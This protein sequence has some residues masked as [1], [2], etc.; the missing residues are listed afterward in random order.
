MKAKT[1]WKYD[2][3]WGGV[4]KI[5]DNAKFLH[6]AFQDGHPM[7]WFEID[8]KEVINGWALQIY[9]TGGDIRDQAEYLDTC[10]DERGFVW[11]LYKL[12]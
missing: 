8:E 10:L 5:P 11:H 6:F 1:V 9:P 7:A 4:L 12:Y 3:N 2:L